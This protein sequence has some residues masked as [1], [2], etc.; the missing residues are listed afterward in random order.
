LG[1]Y[2]SH[3]GATPRG[4]TDHMRGPTAGDLLVTGRQFQ[5]T[6]RS[7]KGSHPL[8]IYWSHEGGHLQGTYKSGGGA[9]TED[10]LVT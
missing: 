6:L 4:H 9:L 7:N 3:E 8:G 10:I 2:K 5:G 1:T